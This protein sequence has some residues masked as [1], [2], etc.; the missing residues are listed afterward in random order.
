MNIK[1]V[2]IV[3]H[4]FLHTHKLSLIFDSKRPSSF[5]VYFIVSRHFSAEFL[6]M[7]RF[8]TVGCALA[9][10]NTLVAG[11]TIPEYF[12]NAPV[13]RRDLSSDKIQRELGGQLSNTTTIFGKDDARFHNA[14]S[15]WNL[16][17]APDY[18]VVIEPG[19]E[20]DISTIV[21]AILSDFCRR[22]IADYTQGQI[23]QR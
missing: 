17:V 21:S 6:E 22:P 11:A 1:A 3:I 10:F 15:R 18:E 16:Y 14:T 4:S 19:Q 8:V 7:K 20:S 12:R 23:L 5:S 9:I 13:T 2:P